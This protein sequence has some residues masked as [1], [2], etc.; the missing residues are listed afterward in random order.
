LLK[1]RWRTETGSPLLY[2]QSRGAASAVQPQTRASH[3]LEQFFSSIQDQENLSILDIAG[4]SQ[5]NISFITA[6]GHR[7]YSNDIVRTLEEAFGGDGEFVANQSD[8]LRA[9]AFLRESLDFPANSF[10]GALV[11][12]TLQFL[13]PPLLQDTV[14]RL[15]HIMR[16]QSY[17]LAFF[18]AEEKADTIPLYSYRIVE[19]KVLSLTPRGQR[20]PS[21]YFNNRSLEKLFQKFNSVKFFL[22]RDH[23]REVIV[24]R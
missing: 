11:W 24:R 9:A 17:L 2:P 21:Q 16:P 3:G 5:A 18:H 22:T 14:D 6:L 19:S 15:F 4:A 20:K 10:D 7:I 23:L 12:D 8:P 13:A 1:D